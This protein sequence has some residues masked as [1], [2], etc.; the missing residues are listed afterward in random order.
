[1]VLRAEVPQGTGDP[2]LRHHEPFLYVPVYLV[3]PPPLII[4]TLYHIIFTLVLP[5]PA[6]LCPTSTTLDCE[7][8]QD[9]AAACRYCSC[10]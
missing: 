1:M 8:R 9:G 5:F 2:L 7:L 10:A 3:N 4:F 6:R